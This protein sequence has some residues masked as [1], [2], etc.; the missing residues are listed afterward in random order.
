MAPTFE[1]EDSSVDKAV[2]KACRELQIPR[3]KLKHDV[4][5]IGRTGVFGLVGTKKA[6]IRVFVPGETT[7]HTPAAE[8]AP[9]DIAPE[10]APLDDETRQSVSTLI[11]ETFEEAPPPAEPLSALQYAEDPVLCGRSAL[12]K[13]IDFI[14]SGAEIAVEEKADRICFNVSGGNAGVLIGKRGQTLEAIQYLV[15]KIV[16]KHQDAHVR[17]QID[18][19]GYLA[20]RRL[21]LE[22]MASRLGDKVKRTGKPITVGQMN[23]HDRRIIHITLKEE[24]GVR[25]QS[26][27]DGYYR[28]LVIF[29]QK[30]SSRKRRDN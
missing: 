5:S 27:G 25:T 3:E 11:E 14:T 24:A 1:F 21:N 20:K 2:E 16:N 28:K 7:R 9:S 15:E 26:L 19:E 18:V 10:A 30:K 17:I 29:P 22:Q 12:Q 4:V 8:E 23:A 6:K 13:I